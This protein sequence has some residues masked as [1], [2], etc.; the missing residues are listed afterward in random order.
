MSTWTVTVTDFGA[1]HREHTT[2]VEAD[3]ADQARWRGLHKL[4]GNDAGWH[5][6]GAFDARRYG[7]VTERVGPSESRTLTG[8]AR[9]DVYQTDR[10]EQTP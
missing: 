10:E 6:D 9:I 5:G 7:Q 3:D 4:F 1:N 2:Q 8:R